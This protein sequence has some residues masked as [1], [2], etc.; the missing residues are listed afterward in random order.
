MAVQNLE[1]WEVRQHR[2]GREGAVGITAGGKALGPHT[3]PVLKFSLVVSGQ[4]NL[5]K[6]FFSWKLFMTVSTKIFYS[7]VLP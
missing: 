3:P 5:L 4:S 1:D 7:L 2:R 6:L